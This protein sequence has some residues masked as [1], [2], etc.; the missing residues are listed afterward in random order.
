MENIFY[1]ILSLFVVIVLAGLLFLLTKKP[2]RAE[3]DA[4]ADYAAG[5]NY[6]VSGD[7]QMALRKLKDAVRKDTTN[8]DAYI[9]IGD[10]L[11]NHG[12]VERAIK[13]HRDLTARASLTPAQQ[14]LVFRSLTI[15]YEAIGAYDAALETLQRIFEIKKDDLWAREKELRLNE[16]KK[17]WQKAEEVY[18]KLAKLKGEKSNARL[19]SY[20][21]EFGRQLTRAGKAKEAREAFRQ[22]IKID[23]TYYPAYVELSENYLQENRLQDALNILKRFVQ[24]NPEAASK[25]F[26]RIRELLFR[27]G[28]FGEIENV[29]QQVISNSTDNWEAYLALAEIKEKKGELNSAI[30]LCQQILQRNP[31]FSKAREHLVRY[32]HRLGD[33]SSAVEQA[34]ALI[35]F[36]SS[37][38]K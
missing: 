33:D 37:N 1:F 7:D 26:A 18:R 21:V 15:D 36:K 14:L 25:A 13:V 38:E 31:D 11:R 29:Y 2:G 28:E 6:L 23:Q 24:T 9:K 8:V 16:L 32:Y 30:D 35:N 19:A 27:I 22:A 17:D 20:R 10:I 34:L 12:E 5:L 3:S 4:A